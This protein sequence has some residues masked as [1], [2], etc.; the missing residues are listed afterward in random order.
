MLAYLKGKKTYIVS[1]CGILYSVF[2][3]VSGHLDSNTAISTIFA[4]LAVMGVR[5]G[6]T[7]EVQNLAALLPD[8]TLP[9]GSASTTQNQK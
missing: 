3:F 4:A 2:G 7:N 1:I 8:K 9:T 6:L 5:G